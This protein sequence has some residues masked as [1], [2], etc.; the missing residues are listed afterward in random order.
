MVCGLVLGF[1]VSNF[2]T[3]HVQVLLKILILSMLMISLILLE[4]WRPLLKNSD[5]RSIKNL[6]QL[7]TSDIFE[8]FMSIIFSSIV[9]LGNLLN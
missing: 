3:E 9:L 6:L 8:Y 2:S 5:S 4:I 7:L 1:M